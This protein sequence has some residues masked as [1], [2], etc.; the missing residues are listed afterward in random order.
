MRL[1]ELRKV[2]YSLDTEFWRVI[3]QY[4]LKKF[5]KIL[6][7]CIYIMPDGKFRDYKSSDRIN[8]DE[9]I[10]E[11]KVLDVLC[12]FRD[13]YTVYSEYSDFGIEI[14]RDLSY[15][16]SIDSKLLIGSYGESLK[17][18]TN[19]LVELLNRHHI[20]NSDTM[21]YVLHARKGEMTDAFFG[22]CERFVSPI[23]EA[24]Y[25]FIDL[26]DFCG[27]D[28]PI[29]V[30]GF[31]HLLYTAYTVL[32]I[33]NKIFKEV[34][35]HTYNNEFNGLIEEFRCYFES[36]KMNVRS[37][38]YLMPYQMLVPLLGKDFRETNEYPFNGDF[39]HFIYNRFS[40]NKIPSANAFKKAKLFSTEPTV[41]SIPI[42]VAFYMIVIRETLKIQ[43]NIK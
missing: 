4:N 15:K 39:L 31:I 18:M 30:E 38:S 37:F 17:L 9:D 24:Q 28:S 35:L 1:S 43:L 32:E 42:T 34:L 5:N 40:S 19:D 25:E 41:K 27:P 20:R 8:N 7:E 11:S 3:S 26:E 10:I 29:V 2:A 16:Q 13:L 6:D 36:D 23:I 12:S 21:S 22:L 33:D 14:L